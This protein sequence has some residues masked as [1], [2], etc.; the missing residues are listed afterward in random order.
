MLAVLSATTAHTAHAITP[1]AALILGA[2]AALF[3]AW[4][5]AAAVQRRR[6]R[7]TVTRALSKTTAR[8]QI[9]A[10]RRSGFAIQAKRSRRAAARF[11]AWLCTALL[12]GLA[13]AYLDLRSRTR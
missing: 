1:A 11:R 2:A 10:L 4:L 12:I 3:L 8:Q 9:R 5:R 6:V 7:R 13:V